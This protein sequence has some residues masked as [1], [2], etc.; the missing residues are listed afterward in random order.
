MRTRPEDQTWTRG[1]SSGRGTRTGCIGL[2]LLT[3]EELLVERDRRRLQR[4]RLTRH[5]GT[6]PAVGRLF[7]SM[8]RDI[9]R[10]TDE[11]VRRVLVRRPWSPRSPSTSLPLP[12][13]E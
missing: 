2:S 7:V 6:S 11:L 8:D 13:G 10:L 9:E 5:P 12:A 3:D 1:P 4:E